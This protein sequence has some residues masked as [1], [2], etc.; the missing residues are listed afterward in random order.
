MDIDLSRYDEFPPATREAWDE[1][2]AKALGARSLKS[3]LAVTLDGIT[4]PP[5]GGPRPDRDPV[6]GRAAGR[7]WSIVQKVPLSDPAAANALV[8]D[9]LAGGADGVDLVVPPGSPLATREATR[10]EPRETLVRVF[11]DV[12]LDMVAVHLTGA[13]DPAA[14]AA[15]VAAVA[16]AS[17]RDPAAIRVRA[18]FDPFAGAL[19]AGGRTDDGLARL[20]PHLAAA[21]AGSTGEPDVSLVSARG[22]VWHALGASDAEQL[23]IALATGRAMLSGLLDAGGDAAAAARLAGRIEFRLVVDQTQFA[24]MARLR[25]FRSLWALVLD[26]FGLPQVPAFVHAETSWRMMTRRDPWVNILRSTIAAFAGAVAGADAITTLPHTAALGPADSAARRLSRN[27]QTVLMQE[28]NLHRVADPAAGAGGI[29]EL[30]DRIAEAGWE[31]FRRIESE[32][33]LA[34]SLASGALMARIAATDAAERALVAKRRV[35]VTGVSTYPLIAEATAAT[36]PGAPLPPPAPGARRLAE[37]FEALRDR[38]DAVTEATGD[39]PALF[40]ATLGSPAAHGP[41]ATWTRNLLAAGGIE[42]AGGEPLADAGAAAAAFAASGAAVACLASDDATYAALAAPAAAAL[43]A[44]GARH[45]LLAGRPP[46]DGE[47]FDATGVD[48]FVHEGLDMV[49]LLDD[50]LER[51]TGARAT[52]RGGDRR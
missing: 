40:L 26:G 8:L 4:V 52:A 49:A 14:V 6:A 36:L 16:E 12:Y 30:T 31:A 34:A 45:V 13:G 48:R 7:R 21:V 44:A 42:A 50:L 23:A 15:A 20:A 18:G 29:E 19:A 38:S 9:E 5:L 33:G 37:P 39:R 51:C 35:P 43:K 2:V 27:V 1:A 47:G 41:R 11:A 3:L 24:S 46:K 17:G 25:A 32:G 22:E 28:S 10:G